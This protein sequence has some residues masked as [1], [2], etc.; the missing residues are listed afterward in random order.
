MANQQSA[1][2]GGQGAVP[3]EQFAWALGALC[4]LHRV[5]F[6]ADLILKQTP[7]PYTVEKL[8]E[9]LRALGFRAAQAATETVV[10]AATFPC[11]AFRRA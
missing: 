8:I 2:G 7:P 3:G 6:D 10:N 11:I 4:A 9:A 5:P 1:G